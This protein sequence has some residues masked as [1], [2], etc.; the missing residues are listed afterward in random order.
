MP[1]VLVKFQLG[2]L[3]G[4]KN[5]RVGKICDFR[6]ITR[7]ISKTVQK[8]TRLLQKMNNKSY[9]LYQTVTTCQDIAFFGFEDGGG[10]PSK[11]CHAHVW[12]KSVW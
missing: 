2:H 4:A 1:K 10:P 3:M 8:W 5:T 7:C 6:Q 11:I 9:L 12:T